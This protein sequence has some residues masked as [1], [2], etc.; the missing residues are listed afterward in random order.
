[1]VFLRA[2][3]HTLNHV[4]TLPRQL[5]RYVERLGLPGR[6]RRFARST[7]ATRRSTSISS[8]LANISD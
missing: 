4:G 3:G 5:L 2:S 8:G 6:L 7:S 1:L